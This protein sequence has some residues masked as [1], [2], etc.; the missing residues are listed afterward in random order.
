MTPIEQARKMKEQFGAAL[1]EPAVAL[2]EVTVALHDAERIT[3]VC[4]FAKERLGFDMLLDL[5]SVDNLGDD[6][7]WT[8]VYELYS[9]AGRTHLRLKTRVAEEKSEV[10]TVTG[11]W[12]GANWLER[13]VYDMMG[14]RF[15]GH[16]ELR[17]I[18]MWEG[19]PHFPLR[20]D[21][22][23]GGKPTEV[24]DVAFT[25]AAP[26]EGGPFVTRPVGKDAAARE[27]RVRIPES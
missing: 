5:A 17:R 25:R 22:P 8:L 23:L 2:G 7:R 15:R 26:L 9:V 6:P 19:Y 1:S 18:L 27:P 21:F 13:E 11:V 12:G 3:E 20:K 10:P 24:P 16:P 14:I 4:E